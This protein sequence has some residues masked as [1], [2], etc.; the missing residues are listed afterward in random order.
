MTFSWELPEED[1][2]QK[3]KS[4]LSRHGQLNDAPTLSM[5]GSP[6]PAGNLPT[7]RHSE[8][9]PRIRTT[10]PTYRRFPYGYVRG[11]L[12]YSMRTWEPYGFPLRACCLVTHDRRTRDWG[13][14]RPQPHPST[15]PAVDGFSVPPSPGAPEMCAQTINVAGLLVAGRPHGRRTQS[16]AGRDV[17]TRLEHT[18]LPPYHNCP[19]VLEGPGS[20]V[21]PHAPALYRVTCGPSV[22]REGT[23]MRFRQRA[24]WRSKYRLA[25]TGKQNSGGGVQGACLAT[26]ESLTSVHRPVLLTLS[27]ALARTEDPR[28]DGGASPRAVHWQPAIN[29]PL[30]SANDI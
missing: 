10:Y 5:V 23:Q 21:H 11:M 3:S 29:F 19:G 6:G 16:A 28:A 17:G 8:P 24:A 4:T 7:L 27:P 26:G 22:L 30:P 13:V 1:A 14:A 12:A 20:A 25:S 15:M 2:A 9:F 18:R